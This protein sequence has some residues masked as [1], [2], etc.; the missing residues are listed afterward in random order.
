[1][2]AW[3]IASA[4]PGAFWCRPTAATSEVYVG[5]VAAARL[6]AVQGQHRGRPDRPGV[7]PDRRIRRPQ[8]AATGPAIFIF[9]FDQGP[10]RLE[11]GGAAAAPPR[12]PSRR[13]RR[14]R[15]DLHGDR[16]GEQGA[17]NF[18]YL[19]DFH[20]GKID[21]LNSTFQKTTLAGNFT[22]PGLPAGYAPFNVAAIGGQLYVAYAKQD[23]DREDEVT[24]K[25]LGFI[26]VFD[27]NGNFQSRL[28]SKGALDAPWGMVQAP[29]GFGDFGGDLLVGNFGNGRI[30]AYDPA[31]G[32]FQGTLSSSPG[33]PVEIESLWGLA[34]G[35]G[36]SAGD[37][38]SLYYAAGPNDETHGLFGKITANAAGTNPV[39]AE[40]AANGD[41]V[42]TGSRDDDTVTVGLDRQ[43]GDI[44]VSAGGKRIGTFDPAAVGTIQFTGLAGNDRVFVSPQVGVTTVLNGGAGNDLLSGGG[45]N[46]VLVGG[47]GTIC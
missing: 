14:G 43:T 6:S 33:H 39:R 9:A 37:A 27:L 29:A 25:G 2:N 4:R 10:S 3:G 8:R 20:N 7:Q 24:G 19:A 44:T 42:I 46:N 31:T 32:A 22:D 35:N 47:T 26:N 38:N 15:G 28:V 1:M 13:S 18:L 5:D 12:T 30:N 21:V 34:F 23:A 41:L 17:G 45:G 16:P 36:V 11:P 40:L